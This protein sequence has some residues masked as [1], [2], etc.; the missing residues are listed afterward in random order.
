MLT[1]KVCG[2]QYWESIFNIRNQ[3]SNVDKFGTKIKDLQTHYRYMA[4]KW[5]QYYVC[6]KSENVVG[7]IGIDN[8]DLR[9]CV[10]ENHKR[11]G[12]GRFMIEEL[13]NVCSDFLLQYSVKVKV[14]NLES[15]KFFESLGFR[16][17]Y[18]ILEK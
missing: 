17:K 6:L 12:I 14:D 13:H 8:E 3:P 18:Y 11:Q 15:L 9:L 7:F 2:P 1:L 10:D 4:T 16:K 5:D